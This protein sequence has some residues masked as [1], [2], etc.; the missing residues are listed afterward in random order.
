M[1]LKKI[2]KNGYQSCCT[3][4]VYH[5][6]LVIIPLDYHI[7]S[8]FYCFYFAPIFVCLAIIIAPITKSSKTVIHWGENNPPAQLPRPHLDPRAYLE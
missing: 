3:S 4:T 8:C 1:S 7:N 5:E 6:R 2:N